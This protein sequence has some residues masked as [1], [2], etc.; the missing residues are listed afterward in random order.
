M[1]ASDIPAS[2]LVNNKKV[3]GI[4]FRKSFRMEY[5]EGIPSYESASQDEKYF[6]RYEWKKIF[7]NIGAVAKMIPNIFIIGESIFTTF[8]DVNKLEILYYASSLGMKIPK[9]VLTNVIGFYFKN[10]VITKPVSEFYD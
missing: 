1:F 6:L 9:T 3:I 4:W 10:D 2:L 5:L 8:S 7:D